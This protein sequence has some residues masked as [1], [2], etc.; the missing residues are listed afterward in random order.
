MANG[1]KQSPERRLGA[2][3][4]CQ[5][6][7][8]KTML[9]GNVRFSARGI[10]L[11]VFPGTW[12]SEKMMKMRNIGRR[13]KIRQVALQNLVCLA[14]VSLTSPVLG[15]E[16]QSSPP[17]VAT[18]VHT[19]TPPT[20]DGLLQESFWK[21]AKPCGGFILLEGEGKLVDDT[22]FRL[23]CDD[24]WLYVGVDCR[25]PDMKALQPVVKGHD[26]GA[27]RDDS[28][29]LFLDPG[30]KGAVYIHYMLSFGNAK[31]E[32]IVTNGNV[33]EYWDVPW[34]S[35]T[36]VREDGWSGE[37]AIPLHVSASVAKLSNMRI[38]VTR[39]RRVPVIDSQHVVIEEKL[40]YS[41]WSPVVKS[42][43]ETEQFRPVTGFAEDTKVRVPPLVTIS[44][45]RV[46]P[47]YL[48]EG[49]TF[50]DVEIEV[51]G[52]SNQ[53]SN[54]R[55]VALDRPASGAA[56]EIVE[57]VEMADTSTRQ[58]RIAVPVDSPC[59]R[60]VAVLLKDP[61]GD[62]TIETFL[63]GDLS[64]INAMTA[65]LD[66]N[67]YTSEPQAFAV[68]RIGLPPETLKG[69]RLEA[70][71]AGGTILGKVTTVKTNSKVA[72][73][74]KRLPLGASEVE[75][76]LC[77]KDGASVFKEQLQLVKRVPKPG[78]EWKIDQE[79]RVVLNNGKPFFPFG[80]VMSGVKADDLAA[81]KKLADHDFNTFM[82][83][84]KTTPE[85]L[86]EY[87]KNAAAHGLFTVSAPDGCVE[88]IEWDAYSR[89]SGALL[90]KVKRVTE[91]QNTLG[92]KGVLTLPIPIFARNA[93]Y[94]EFYNK[95]I[96]R[97]LRGIEMTKGYENVAGYFILDE[98]MSAQYFDEYKFGQDYYARIHRADGYHPVLVNYSSHIPEGDQY[99]NW[100]DIL[101]TDPYWIP[102]A[103]V[104]TRTTPNH[105]SK[106]TWM[107]NSRALAH[108]QAVWEILAGPTWSRCFKRP[109]NSRET[110]S[111]T[112]LALIHQATGI[113]F[114]A[115][116]NARATD[117]STFKQLGVEM[118]TLTPFI[119]GPEVEQEVTYRRAVL[120]QPKDKARFADNPFNPAKEQ[121]PDVQSLVLSDPNGNLMLLACNSRH[122]PVACRFEI[123]ALKKAAAYLGSPAIVVRDGAFVET[124]EPYATRAWRIE[125]KPYTGPVALTL[126]QTVL[127]RD[128]PNPETTLPNAWRK[129]RKNVMPNPGFEDAIA[130]GCPD[131]CRISNGATLQEG[132]AL[133]G[134][135]CVRLEKTAASGYEFIHMHCDPQDQ[136]PQTYTLS[137]YLK[138]SR[139]GLN[140][141]LRGTQMNP[142]KPYGECTTINLTTSWKRYS[143]TGV[144]PARVSEAIH[145]IRLTQ[146]GTMWVDGVQ[147]ERG[148]AAT[149]FEE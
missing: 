128:L 38:N 131:Y 47:Y 146:P 125:L 133:F 141:W 10:E 66:R 18:V 27:C 138:G 142:E 7:V 5:R 17:V 92:L 122:H 137:L 59:S 121:Y 118:K 88:K 89:Y 86:V 91:D 9:H 23:A 32:R 127:E 108:R 103:A 75:V 83:W 117:W 149:E 58:L 2:W 8:G 93:I 16:T 35:A 98:P 60:E 70:R 94:G 136:K 76:A 106:I 73:P 132:D 107:T 22:T 54:L 62:E 26:R 42:F 51:K 20:M 80:M 71:A 64:A 69:L 15:A 36:H 40:E 37:I 33:K 113:F 100:C 45:A 55:V 6:K 56:K 25:N 74:L 79:H 104:D 85:G 120:S 24:A 82:V 67:Y 29:E 21:E 148:D 111:Q 13:L 140:A 139:N 1:V 49:R 57:S 43:H 114:F 123:P 124:L 147:L 144:I 102:P 110:R 46:Q 145:E 115:Y 44:A 95:N 96:A 28:V 129:D 97:C 31:D 105:V 12:T 50:Y 130:E 135:R 126:L 112:Y 143:I 119:V 53:K 81:F 4:A 72:I 99:V 101:M 61:V 30:T 39:N 87:Q 78:L 52:Y 116:P 84:S 68:C 63:I 34:R 3:L 11:R 19:A 14:V 134:K 41:S 65:F 48:K 77:G 109:L 90:E